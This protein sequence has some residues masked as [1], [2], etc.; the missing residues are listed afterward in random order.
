MID[1]TIL[2]WTATWRPC[3][4]LQS[5]SDLNI[6]YCRNFKL[7]KEL[8]LLSPMHEGVMGD[9]RYMYEARILW[10]CTA[11]VHEGNFWWE[12]LI[13]WRSSHA[14]LVKVGKYLTTVLLLLVW[15]ACINNSPLI[16]PRLSRLCD[17]VLT[18][19]WQPWKRVWV[20]IGC[21]LAREHALTSDTYGHKDQR[22]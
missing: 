9:Y 19:L 5:C 11:M 10:V 13:K 20:A 17:N 15:S 14:I 21:I 12:S 8:N 4:L 3:I 7:S 16:L 6:L 22:E 2:R 18:T 1:P